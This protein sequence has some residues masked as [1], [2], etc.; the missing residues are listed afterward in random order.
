[1][2]LIYLM[3]LIYHINNVINKV[4]FMTFSLNNVVTYAIEIENQLKNKSDTEEIN[5][6]IIMT[7]ENQKYSHLRTF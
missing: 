2:K 7:F 5:I 1:M 3:K 6:Q 4:Y